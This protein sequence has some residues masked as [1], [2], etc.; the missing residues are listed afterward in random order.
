MSGLFESWMTELVS[1]LIQRETEANVI[2]VDWISLAHQLY[3]DAV[4]HTQ[5]VGLSIAQM[6]NWLQV[7]PPPN[8]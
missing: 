7:A 8:I 6:L 4:N 3:P 1:A 5:R 2:I